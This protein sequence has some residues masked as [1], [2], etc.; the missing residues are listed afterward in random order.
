MDNTNKTSNQQSGA[1]LIFSLI[2]LLVLTMLGLTSMRNATL[3]EKMAYN[4]RDLNL[5]FEAAES[6]LRE[7][8]S[9]INRQNSEANISTQNFVYQPGELPDLS[10]QPHS[11]WINGDNTGSYDDIDASTTLEEVN[12]PPRL[13]IEH[14]AFVPD[15]LVVG[16]KPPTGKNIY[17]ATA[18]GTG[19]TDT[20][21]SITQNTFARRFN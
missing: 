6:G 13:V 15:S 11:W 5:A 12:E 20:A 1:A 16:F 14:R 4:M 18:R 8:E 19:A 17:R 2:L 9:W 7:A 21:Q 3:E 10:N